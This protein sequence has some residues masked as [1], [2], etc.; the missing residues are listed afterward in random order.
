MNSTQLFI[1]I[2][3]RGHWSW[4]EIH[5]WTK[6]KHLVIRKREQEYE[7]L[8]VHSRFA[9]VH[10]VNR[11]IF[12]SASNIQHP[13]ST[14]TRTVAR[15]I[16]F[17][18]TRIHQRVIS[19]PFKILRTNILTAVRLFRLLSSTISP[20]NSVSSVASLIC[21]ASSRLLIFF[22]SQSCVSSWWHKRKQRNKIVKLSY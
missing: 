3:W 21:D 13:A 5:I 15:A 9:A 2:T 11:K 7:H 6:I 14:S 17:T 20:W 1:I 8:P 22:C 12:Q 19:F 4:H 18:C 16:P 10:R